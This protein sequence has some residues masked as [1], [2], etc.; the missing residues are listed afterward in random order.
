M[1]RQVIVQRDEV[2][3]P[4]HVTGMC[5]PSRTERPPAVNKPPLPSFTV[6]RCWT[7]CFTSW[8]P[9]GLILAR[10]KV[11]W[12]FTAFLFDILWCRNRNWK[13]YAQSKYT[14]ESSSRCLPSSYRPWLQFKVSLISRK[15]KAYHVRS[16]GFGATFHR[17]HGRTPQRFM[18]YYFFGPNMGSLSP[19]RFCF[20]YSDI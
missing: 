18:S 9:Q 7:N 3:C 8:N 11:K 6:I 2:T 16:W 12:E 17:Q 20:L 15:Q 10:R 19:P 14:P 1:F 5:I 13:A 4:S